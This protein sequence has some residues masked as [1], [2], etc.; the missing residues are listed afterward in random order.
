MDTGGV[1][2]SLT[3]FIVLCSPSP[4]SEQD[5]AWLQGQHQPPPQA[6][7]HHAEGSLREGAPSNESQRT[8]LRIKYLRNVKNPRNIFVL[9]MPIKDLRTVR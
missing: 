2:L 5:Y 4:H 9:L 3:N 8:S 7:L 6:H 1:R